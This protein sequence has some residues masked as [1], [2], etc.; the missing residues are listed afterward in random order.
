MYDVHAGTLKT[1]LQDA[2]PTVVS[3]TTIAHISALTT[4]TN[5]TKITFTP[6]SHDA[7][8]HVIAAAGSEVVLVQSSNT[9]QTTVKPPAHAPVVIFQGHGGVVATFND[10]GTV[11]GGNQTDAADRVIVGTAGADRIIVADAKD[12][13]VV[14]GSGNSTVHTGLGV[15]TIEAGLGNSTIT[16]GSGGDYAVVKLAGAPNNYTVTTSNGHAIVTHNDTGKTTDISKIQ[17]VQLDQGQALVFAKN[18]VEGKVGTLYHTAFGRYADAGGLDYW[19]DFVKRGATIKN[20]A[21]LFVRTV[22]FATAHPATET[23]TEFVQ[24]LYR[25]TFNRAGEDIGVAFWLTEMAS[26]QSKADIITAFAA[27]AVQNIMN[28]EPSTEA[29]IVGNVSIV[30]GIV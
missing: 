4:S 7:N 15:D 29:V 9:L 23:N 11:P 19:F 5:D 25:N 8:G 16:G 2:S 30:T 3:D 12:T 27:I 28:Q 10:G 1:A 14:L 13:M 26:G 18:D 22:E 17:F 24:S 6:A 21:T 20:V